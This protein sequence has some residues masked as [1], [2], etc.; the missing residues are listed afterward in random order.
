MLAKMREFLFVNLNVI[1][2]DYY[3]CRILSPNNR[4]LLSF[5]YII[6]LEVI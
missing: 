3:T 1:L 4:G 6:T 2:T 5:N